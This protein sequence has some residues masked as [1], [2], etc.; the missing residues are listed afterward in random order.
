M[1]TR[2]FT[3]QTMNA[4]GDPGLLVEGISVKP[5][6]PTLI[7]DC[8]GKPVLGL[9]GHPVSAVTIFKIFGTAI[10]RRLS[11]DAE[12]AFKPSVRAKLSRNIASSTG[13]TDYMRIRLEKDDENSL[14]YAV[15][16]FGRS[17]MLKTMVEADGYLVVKAGKEGLAA[18]E[19]VDVFLFE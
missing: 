6:K 8:H 19:E 5:G 18:G 2:D 11:G 16:V 3:A 9:P 14:L 15:P 4:L 12:P 7:A 1:G 13:R 10:L 17:G